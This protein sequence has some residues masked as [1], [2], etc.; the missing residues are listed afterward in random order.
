[1][2]ILETQNHTVCTPMYTR[3]LYNDYSQT[4]PGNI[5]ITMV[6]QRGDSCFL[7]HVPQ[8]KSV[9]GSDPG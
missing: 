9:D 1:M 8:P 6:Q 4:R 2:Y 7:R 3:V 5:I